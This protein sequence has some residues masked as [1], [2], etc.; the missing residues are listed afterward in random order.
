MR[1]KAAIRREIGVRSVRDLLMAVGF[2][3]LVCAA[4][5]TGAEDSSL[6]AHRLAGS[7][8]VLVGDLARFYSLGH[9]QS[10]SRERAVYQTT[11]AR[12]VL[13]AD[14][15]EMQI[16][17]VQQWLSSPVLSARGQLWVAAVDVLKAIDPVF[18]QGRSRTPA[19]IRMVVIDPGHGGTDR[20]TRGNSGIEKEMTLDLAKRL[21][22]YL[23][24][25]GVNVLMTRTSDA[26]V[27]L[28]DRV[29]FT[30]SKRADLFV[31]LHF[32]SGGTAS[33]IETYCM[34]PAGTT[35]TADAGA[36]QVYRSDEERSPN[37]RFDEKNVWLAHCAQKSLLKTTGGEDRGVRRARFYVLRYA[38]CPAILVEAGFLTNRA[39]EQKILSTEY[40]GQLARA[41]AEGILTYKKSVESR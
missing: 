25:E 27:S 23:E 28:E 7:E 2:S 34:P 38:S 22:R 1:S 14:H 6:K 31:S 18:R 10:G 36:R 5:A 32:N 26:T 30:T 19:P 33:G 17:G 37:N 16:N 29:D 12:L 11:V 20:G 15:R 8:Y 13:E 21:E 24:A 3:A 40:R 9:N 4:V 39:E 35:S 41:I